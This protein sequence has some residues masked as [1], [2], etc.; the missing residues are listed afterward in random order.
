MKNIHK[1]G[2]SSLLFED[3]YKNTSL[4]LIKI[5]ISNKI[6]FEVLENTKDIWARDY[7]PIITSDNKIISY[8]YKPEYLKEYK[9][10]RTD[11]NQI[12]ISNKKLAIDFHSNIIL[13]GGN[14]IHKDNIVLMTDKIYTENEH[15]SKNKEIINNII[16]NDFNICNLI[17]LPK[18]PYD[19]YGH[20]DSMVRFIAENTLL[21]N[22]F[23]YESKSYQK[24]LFEVLKNTKYNLK[25]LKYSN[26]FFNS[27]R[28]WGAYLN[29][30]EI[31]D[32]IIVPIYGISEDLLVLNQFKTIFPKKI[33]IPLKA[34]KIISNGGALNCIS[35]DLIR[36]K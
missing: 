25:Y 2:L 34:T 12:T 11:I 7:M 24:K 27:K 33:I 18:V 29:Y 36:I 32:L 10:I 8:N 20:S 1:I 14:F 9:N 4:K 30:L 15:I 5:L 23:S 28:T 19:I 16:K 21:V 31:K 35:S 26:S 13:D 3:T 6:D 22:D 17:I